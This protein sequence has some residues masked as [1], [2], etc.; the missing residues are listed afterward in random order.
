MKKILTVGGAMQDVFI[1][2]ENIDT[3]KVQTEHQDAPYICIPAGRKIE[4]QDIRY[5]CGGGAANS[6]V[7]FARLGLHVEI[8]F[9]IGNDPAGDFI[10]HTLKKEKVST[11][12]VIRTDS[13][14]TGRSF[15]IPGPHGN[16]ALLVHRGANITLTQQEIPQ[17]A[18]KNAD[19][20]YIT[21]LSGTA[22]PLLIPLTEYAKKYNKQVAANP[23]TSQLLA[24]A[25][26]L[27]SAL[28]HIDTLILNSYEAEL[29]MTSL[30]TNIMQ[31]NVRDLQNCTV[32]CVALSEGGSK[33][34]P[35][36]LRKQMGSATT[37][38]TLVQ[39]FKAVHTCG[40]TTI[41]VTNGAEGVYA[42][43]GSTLYF[44]P[45]IPI[46]MVSSVGAGDAFGSCFVAQRMHGT[47]IEDALRAGIINSSSVIKH[48]GA[49]TGLLTQEQLEQ[50]CK[51]LDKSLLKKFNLEK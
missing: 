24:G 51:H 26:F 11:L 45:S 44:H 14:P 46:T 5:H 28:S 9:K 22:A 37:C 15:I 16:N 50:H 47:S 25:D 7:S 39:F 34:E 8:F 20:L 23:G 12:A 35:E 41:V 21:S 6:A 48:V 17:N 18:I 36:L 2:Y 33:V 29:L 32:S 31:S 10:L 42:S 13:S 40:P 38:F 1:Q 30:N 4:V 19:Q 49:Q 43:D 3:L 27:K